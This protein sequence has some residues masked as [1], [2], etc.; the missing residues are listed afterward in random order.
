MTFLKQWNLNHFSRET[1]PPVS[2]YVLYTERKS[3]AFSIHILTAPYYYFL[4]LLSIFF[5]ILFF[6]L[7][8]YFSFIKKKNEKTMALKRPRSEPYFTENS[9]YDVKTGHALAYINELSCMYTCVSNVLSIVRA[10]T[11]HG[12]HMP[13]H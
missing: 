10:S 13:D 5:Y 8:I 3:Y 4:M 6:L 12:P 1:R 7:Y 9:I 11:R 2:Y